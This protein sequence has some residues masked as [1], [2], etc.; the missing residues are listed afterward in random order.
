[1]ALQ[2]LGG[3][4]H[5]VCAADA[6]PRGAGLLGGG[7]GHVRGEGMALQ[8][9]GGGGHAVR[10]ADAGPRGAGLLGGGRRPRHA[11]PRV[12]GT[13]G[14]DSPTPPQPAGPGRPLPRTTGTSPPRQRGSRPTSL[15]SS[16]TRPNV[17]GTDDMSGPSPGLQGHPLPADVTA[18]PSLRSST[19]RPSVGGTDGMDIH[20][21]PRPAGPGRPL[22][23]TTGTSPPRRRDSRPP[24]VRSSTT[25]PNV[26]RTDGMTGP[27]PGLEGHLLPADV[28]A[29]PCQRSSTAG[30]SVTWPPP[31]SQQS[32]TVR[33]SVSGT[34]DMSGPSPGLQ[35][36]PLPAAS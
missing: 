33:P 15:R 21:P 13:D 18:A 22:P 10:V 28:A 26:S 17:S 14:M 8:A 23:Q 6:R 11:G 1:M 36:H 19:A 4:A 35:G 20:T 3:A 27:S 12:S 25:R 16:T 32:S 31:P 34:D 30:P 29:A 7:D 2:A 24:S 9:R 5:V